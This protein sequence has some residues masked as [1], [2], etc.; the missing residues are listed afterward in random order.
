MIRRKLCGEGGVRLRLA[1]WLPAAV[2]LCLVAAPVASSSA[3]TSP[4]D[5]QIILKAIG[6]LT[7]KPSGGFP[8]AI[9]FEPANPASKQDAEAVKA[10]LDG[11][12]A[13]SQAKLLPVDQLAGFEGVAAVVAAGTSPAG[14]DAVAAAFKG[15]KVLTVSTD[16]TCAKQGKCVVSVTSDPQVEILFNVKAAEAAGVDFLP[17]F[18][19][20][21]TQI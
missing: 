3:A 2:A 19:M 9:V 14:Q 1:G 15:R 18:R 21:I 8:V 13:V 16:A 17:N 6:F 20:M 11:V 4:K 12:A 5:V 10:V 7:S